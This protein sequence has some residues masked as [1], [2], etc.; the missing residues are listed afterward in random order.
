LP[1]GAQFVALAIDAIPILAFTFE[2]SHLFLTLQI[3]DD[4]GER[5]LWIER[6]ELRYSTDSW[7]IKLEGR[8]LTLREEFRKVLCEIKFNPPDS[9]EISR[10]RFALNGLEL[11]VQPDCICYANNGMTFA[12]LGG[13]LLIF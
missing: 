3:Y 6:K 8:T 4:D 11:L 9:V 5:A 13:L 1:E 10:G 2:Q 12:R 7:D